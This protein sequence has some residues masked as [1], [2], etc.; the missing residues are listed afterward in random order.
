MTIIEVKP[1]ADKLNWGVY[2]GPL[3]NQVLVGISKASFDADFA[4][5]QL[6]K[7]YEE[8]FVLNHAG[9][10]WLDQEEVDFARKTKR[11]N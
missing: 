1:T 9:R 5:W 11:R 3:E 10:R 8:P 6:A 7:L 4:A 2:V